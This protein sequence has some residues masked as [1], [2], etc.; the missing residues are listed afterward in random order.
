VRS[1][2]YR[3]KELNSGSG[4]LNKL[5]ISNRPGLLRSPRRAG[6]VSPICWMDLWLPRISHLCQLGL[7]AIAIIVYEFTV[8]PVYEIRKL[9]EEIS[10]KTLSLSKTTAELL[11]KEAKLAELIPKLKAQEKAVEDS[12]LE[13]RRY[14]IH[15]FINSIGLVCSGL[16]IPPKPPHL[17]G[18]KG[19]DGTSF[20]EQI[21]HI[22]PTGCLQNELKNSEK[23]KRLRKEDF[24]LLSGELSRI[25]LKLDV[26]RAA[27][28][29]EYRGFPAK[30]ANDPSILKLVKLGPI[31]EAFLSLP[32]DSRLRESLRI[33]SA[34]EQ[35]RAAIV[36]IYA[37]RMRKEFATLHSLEKK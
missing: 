10:Q 28:I 33:K 24:E 4:K 6:N 21:L 11:H 5:S 7:L 9:E 29:K 17:F 14:S 27:V 18:K 36:H 35:G 22:D 20:E 34:I 15:S 37:D 32:M 31:S 30:A 8:I 19:R 16:L 1:L 2:F 12:Y 23:L 13:I 26:E 25:A 3:N